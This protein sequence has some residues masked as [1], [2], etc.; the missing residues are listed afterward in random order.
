MSSFE[1]SN[2]G[3]NFKGK[4]FYLM[5]LIR[6]IN[7]NVWKRLEPTFNLLDVNNSYEYY[8][9]LIEEYQ[10]LQNSGGK[11]LGAIWKDGKN[12]NSSSDKKDAGGDKPKPIINIEKQKKK[13]EKRAE[14][15]AAK[16]VEEK[17]KKKLEKKEVKQIEEKAAKKTAKKT[18]KK[19]T[20]K[21][22]KKKR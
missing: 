11:D 2:K 17:S 9:M 14:D 4:C 19:K 7:K 22:T 15:I 12:P 18:A 21:K 3:G 6:Q 16:S 1:F 20:K 8:Q 5:M 10:N 13:E